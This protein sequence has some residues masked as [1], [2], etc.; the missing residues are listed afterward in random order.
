MIARL[1]QGG[2]A[3]ATEKN[4]EKIGALRIYGTKREVS[5]VKSYRHNLNNSHTT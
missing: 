4:E 3:D 1:E 2:D 5:N